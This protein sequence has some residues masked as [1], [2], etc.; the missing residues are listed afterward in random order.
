MNSVPDPCQPLENEIKVKNSTNTFIE[1]WEE[2]RDKD[3]E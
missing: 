2:T 3:K 1:V